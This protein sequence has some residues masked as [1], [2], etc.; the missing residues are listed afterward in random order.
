MCA[1][2]ESL[3]RKLNS[4][5]LLPFLNLR[6]FKFAI[7]FQLFCAL[8]ETLIIYNVFT[9][10]HAWWLKYVVHYWVRETE[11]RKRSS[12]SWQA[13]QRATDFSKINLARGLM[14]RPACLLAVSPLSLALKM[15]STNTSPPF[16]PLSTYESEKESASMKRILSA[17][18]H[19]K[20]ERAQ[21]Q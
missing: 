7:I 16:V 10:Y 17:L 9:C 13:H 19:E 6:L 12:F 2:S 1:K 8:N 15:L 18:S 14:R 11:A 4:R 21:K 3:R 20:N 5:F